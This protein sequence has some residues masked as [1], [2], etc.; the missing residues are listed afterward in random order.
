[1]STLRSGEI[2]TRR[3]LPP[4]SLLALKVYV[5]AKDQGNPSLSSLKPVPVYVLIG[6]TFPITVKML[7]RTATTITL[8]FTL[9]NATLADVSHIGIVVQEADR[10]Y[11]CKC[12][13]LKSSWGQQF[14]AGFSSSKLLVLTLGLSLIG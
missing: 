14:K 4:I 7:G 13:S 11:D 8:R 2:T 3:S 6:S 5:S 9:V 10:I 12:L 1:M